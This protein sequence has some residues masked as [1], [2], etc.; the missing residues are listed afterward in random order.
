MLDI[1]FIRKKP[2]IVRNAIKNRKVDTKKADLDKFLALDTQKN[3]LDE[4]MNKR[5][6]IRNRINRSLQGRPD[7]ETRATLTK[8]KQEIVELRIKWRKVDK[9]W[10]KIMDWL[11]NIPL[12]DV[13]IGKTERDNIEI[14]AWAPDKGYLDQDQLSGVDGSKKFMPKFAA[15]SNKKFKLKPHWEIGE[16]LDL[17]DTEAGSKTSGSRFYY[18]KNELDKRFR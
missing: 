8:L 15:H 1:G 3:R 17:I 4:Q 18:L 6:E 13:P 12:K 5:R 11:P 7:D 9:E 2:D 14:K 10:K 16:Q